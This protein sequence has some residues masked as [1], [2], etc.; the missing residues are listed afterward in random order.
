MQPIKKPERFWIPNLPELCNVLQLPADLFSVKPNELVRK[1]IDEMTYG[2]HYYVLFTLIHS[3]TKVQVGNYVQN[4][5]KFSYKDTPCLNKNGEFDKKQSGEILFKKN[6]KPDEFK[7]V[8]DKYLNTAA[9]K[10]FRS[11][12]N[13]IK[14]QSENN[15]EYYTD[16]SKNTVKALQQCARFFYHRNYL[17]FKHYPSDNYDL[18][19]INMYKDSAQKIIDMARHFFEKDFFTDLPKIKPYC[20]EAWQNDVCV[21]LTTAASNHFQNAQNIQKVFKCIFAISNSENNIQDL[22]STLNSLKDN[23]DQETKGL[24]QFVVYALWTRFGMNLEKKYN[25]K[26]DKN[27]DDNGSF[28]EKKKR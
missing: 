19:I 4:P 28:I 17:V 25:L 2:M 1:A 21:Q 8:I 23:H 5:I 10:D 22:L 14:F 9:T 3:A 7:E 24:H 11:L 15:K 6:M 12:L 26:P 13:H 18:E 27:D 20:T 16:K